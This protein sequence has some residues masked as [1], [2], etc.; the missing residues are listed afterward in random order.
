QE[1]QKAQW[2]L[3]EAVP[4]LVERQPDVVVLVAGREGNATSELALRM[5]DPIVRAHVRV[6]GH[7]ADVPDLLAASDVFA[8]PSI[9]EGL[10]GSVIEAMALGLPI[11]ASDLSALREV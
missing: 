9:F 11:V 8:F 4:R 3:L 5:R 1:R 2:A 10:G 6:L 7:R